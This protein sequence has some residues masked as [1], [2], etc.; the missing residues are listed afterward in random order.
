MRSVQARWARR[1]RYDSSPTQALGKRGALALVARVA[2]GLATLITNVAIGRIGGSAVLGLT[3]SV[4]ASASIAALLNPA[5]SV[6]SRYLASER[7]R[8][9]TAEPAASY[10]ARRTAMISSVLAI[11]TALVVYVLGQAA[12]PTALVTGLMVISITGRTF[13][14]GLH[15]G[16]GE[17]SRLALW[18]V[19]IAILSTVGVVTLALSGVRDA[20]ILTP[21]I[22]PTL[23]FV[24]TSWPRQSRARIDTAL[25]REM[26]TFMIL[27]TFGTLASSG[28]S[29]GAILVATATNGLAYSG[30][31]AAAFTLVTPLFLVTTAV[32]SVLFPALAAAHST[33]QV[34]RISSVLKSAT[35]A[36]V[37]TVIAAFIVLAIASGVVV[38][39]VWGTE[40]H[41]VQS[42]IL[43][44]LPAIVTSAIA[45]PAVNSITSSSNRGMFVSVLSSTCG[46]LIGILTWLI[47]IP[48]NPI[49]GVP[50]GFCV[51]TVSIALV[52]LI[53]AWTRFRMRWTSE[54]ITTIVAMLL[55]MI[56]SIVL[57]RCNIPDVYVLVMGVAASAI[58][59]VVRRR[60]LSTLIS[61]VRARE[62]GAR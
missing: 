18:S 47:A 25:R 10:L 13:T 32:G 19:M 50:I 27:A 11:V 51:G 30:Q 6:A 62:N 29:Q 21:I 1:P 59:C 54:A 23:L 12:I 56:I 37:T 35:S 28:F 4:M 36:L 43:V 40:F 5:G 61:V 16:G 8:T 2:P 53:I 38:R 31:Y 58:W 39:L 34:T 17:N 15:F 7:S 22:V 20:W 24:L 46:A 9:G 42:I 45:A 52:P 60:S 48:I 44:L 49:L 41:L 33:A 55:T 26:G 14:E 57:M 3:Q